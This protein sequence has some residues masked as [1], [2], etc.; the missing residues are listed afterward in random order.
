MRATQAE[1][2]VTKSDGI[3]RRR[4]GQGIKASLCLRSRLVTLREDTWR[5]KV[6]FFDRPPVD[7]RVRGERVQV[8]Q[9]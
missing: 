7:Q 8:C 2:P 5:V 3:S 1:Q 9:R 4:D 6:W